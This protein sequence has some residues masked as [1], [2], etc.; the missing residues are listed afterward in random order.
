MKNYSIHITK[1]AER[2][3]ANAANYI[4]FALKNPQ[5]AEALLDIV[6]EKINNIAIFPE[7]FAVIEDVV[8]SSWGI[9]F[10]AIKNYLAFYLID[11]I[12]CTIH[13]VRFLYGKRNYEQI[14]SSFYGIKASEYATIIAANRRQISSQHSQFLLKYQN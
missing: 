7:K 13:V 12:T 14:C 8:L 2:D 5:A 11:E 9:R 1:A 3:I 4:E 6:E 10:V